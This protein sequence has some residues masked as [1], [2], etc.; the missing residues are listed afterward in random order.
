VKDT[1]NRLRSISCHAKTD[2]SMNSHN[3][4]S[5]LAA[6]V[7]GLGLSQGADAQVAILD[8]RTPWNPVNTSGGVGTSW[9]KNNVYIPGGA[10]V[11]AT[12]TITGLGNGTI[13]GGTTPLI[14]SGVDSATPWLTYTLSFDDGANPVAVQNVYLTSF[15][16]DGQSGTDL[17]EFWGYKNTSAPDIVPPTLGNPTNIEAATFPG[18]PGDMASYT[19]F[20]PKISTLGT[21]AP[22]GDGLNIGSV[23]APWAVFNQYGSLTSGEYFYGFTGTTGGSPFNRQVIMTGLQVPESGTAAGSLI[24][25]SAMIGMA[26]RRRRK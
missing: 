1:K 23:Q 10:T 21:N 13:V 24:V 7:I 6:A 11:N 15:D 12:L 25:G 26:S 18:G 22:V 17:R 4:K 14:L 20:A 16:L 9:V 19:T 8:L 5:L 2:Y 3:Q